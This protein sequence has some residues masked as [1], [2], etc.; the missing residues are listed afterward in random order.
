MIDINWLIHE[1]PGPKPDC[2]GEIKLFLLK[3]LSI[4]FNVSFSKNLSRIG[5]SETGR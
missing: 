3:K 1:S 2:L 5:K 4:S